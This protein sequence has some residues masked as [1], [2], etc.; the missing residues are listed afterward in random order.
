MC[1][2]VCILYIR[3]RNERLCQFSK[4]TFF[5]YLFSF[6]LQKGISYQRSYSVHC[7]VLCKVIVSVR[8]LIVSRLR[9]TRMITKIIYY[10]YPWNVWFYKRSCRD[11]YVIK[12][13]L[14]TSHKYASRKNGRIIFFH[15]CSAH[16]EADIIS[17]IIHLCY[18]Y[19]YMRYTHLLFFFSCSYPQLRKLRAS[20]M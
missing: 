6:I 17:Y 10:M 3:V 13:M 5:F 20:E 8:T 14:I 11:K 19:I 7:N 15:I 2:H 16:I 1:V 12:Q 18:S 4:F 9:E